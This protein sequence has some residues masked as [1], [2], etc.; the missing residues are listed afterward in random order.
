MASTDSDNLRNITKL[1]L[2]VKR[3]VETL[4]QEPAEKIVDD[5][6]LRELVREEVQEFHHHKGGEKAWRREPRGGTN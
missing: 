2:A 1:V 4:P 6:Q 3:L 5:P